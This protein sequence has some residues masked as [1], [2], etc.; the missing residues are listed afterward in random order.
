MK[1][2]AV[3]NQKGG[4]GKTTIALHLAW[5]AQELGH[6]VLVI[7][8]DPQ[9]NASQVLMRDVKINLRRGGAALMFSRGET[10]EPLATPAG[11]DLLNGHQYLDAAEADSDTITERGEA[12]RK[13]DYTTVIFDCPPSLSKLFTA[14]LHWADRLIIPLTAD[15]FTIS[16][17]NGTLDLL[18]TARTENPFLAERLVL[19]M[20]TKNARAA[21]IYARDL[22]ATLTLKEPFLAS[23]AMVREAVAH[24][25]PVWA[26]RHITPANN[27]LRA[28]R[29]VRGQWQIL[30]RGLLHD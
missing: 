27:S 17:L 28:P 21:Q 5:A 13:L 15:F 1:V 2:F 9:G 10:L 19:N 8:L 6:R 3:T 22:T 11:I 16:G 4:V 20:F 7:D 14:P 18:D 26:Y 24:S 12:L 30:C 25:Q 23:S 29:D